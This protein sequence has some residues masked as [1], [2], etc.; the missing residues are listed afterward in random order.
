M[1][2]V[3]SALLVQMD[4]ARLPFKLV[5]YERLPAQLYDLS[6]D[7]HERS[8]I[9]SHEVERTRAMQQELAEWR[10]RWKAPVAPPAAPLERESFEALSALGYT[11]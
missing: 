5:S 2:C 8:D 1:F 9:A 3:D 6:W 11:N 4:P 10:A 7:P